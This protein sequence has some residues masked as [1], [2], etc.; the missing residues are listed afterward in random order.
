MFYKQVEEI[1]ATYCRY[2]CTLLARWDKRFCP[3]RDV[4][5]LLKSDKCQWSHCELG[6]SYFYPDKRFK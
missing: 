5:F 3:I 2:I 4:R 6:D 1:L